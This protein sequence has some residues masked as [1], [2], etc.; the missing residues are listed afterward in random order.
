MLYHRVLP[1]PHSMVYFQVWGRALPVLI[2]FGPISGQPSLLSTL[3]LHKRAW[4]LASLKVDLPRKQ[5]PNLAVPYLPG[6][7]C[8]LFPSSAST[9]LAILAWRAGKTHSHQPCWFPWENAGAV[10][11]LLLLLCPTRQPSVRTSQ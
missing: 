6:S 2:R 1:P 3:S 8:E 4:P 7:G 10:S 5:M 9:L 11:A